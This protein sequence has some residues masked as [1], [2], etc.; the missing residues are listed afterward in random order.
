M[1]LN[2]RWEKQTGQYQNGENLFL[3]KIALGYV[4]WNSSL[5][6]DLPE[7]EKNK[8]QYV[9]GSRLYIN[10]QWYG[11]TEEEVKLQIEKAITI[12]FNEALKGSTNDG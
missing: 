10:K 9:G 6:R 4:G 2:F 1:K 11:S 3:N 8:R 12:W 7:S 5:S